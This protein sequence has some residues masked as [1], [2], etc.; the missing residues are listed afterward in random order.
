MPGRMSLPLILAMNC[1]PRGVLR[2]ARGAD[3]PTRQAPSRLS[4][5]RRDPLG[6]GGLLRGCLWWRGLWRGRL[7][8]LVLVERGRPAKLH[9][10]DPRLGLV[11]GL[12][13]VGRVHLAHEILEVLVVAA[14]RH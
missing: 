10:G 12:G 8:H 14:A 2:I 7:A 3:A 13:A 5:I 1:P 9:L 4:L 11:L 6:L